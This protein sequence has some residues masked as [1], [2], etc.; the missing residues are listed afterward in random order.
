[1]PLGG[2]LV[3]FRDGVNPV[4][5]VTTNALGRYDSGNLPAGSYTVKITKTGFAVLESVVEIKLGVVSYK[6]WLMGE[7][8][9]NG[10]IVEGSFGV[11]EIANIPIPAGVNDDATAEMEV[12]DTEGG[13]FASN[14]VSGDVTGS[15]VL[16]AND[17]VPLPMKWN[18][19]V[20]QIGLDGANPFYNVKNVG[21]S[22][23]TWR[24]VFTLA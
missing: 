9:G 12:Y 15:G 11:N 24:V 1:V 18:L 22:A 23:G 16:Y 20:A 6:H 21:A 7:A 2:A 10:V 4:V 17:S 19:V 5:E 8:A 3:E 14:S 13:F